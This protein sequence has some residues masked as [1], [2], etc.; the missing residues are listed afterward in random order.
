LHPVDILFPYTNKMI[1]R[2]DL[3]GT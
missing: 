1:F 2:L 3:N